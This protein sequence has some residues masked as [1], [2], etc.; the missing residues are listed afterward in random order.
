MEKFDFV[1]MLKNV[2][3]YRITNLTL[4]PPVVVMLAK[5]PETRNFDLSS[6]KFIGSGAAP[7]SREVSEEVENMWPSGTINVKQGW[8]MTEYVYLYLSIVCIGNLIIE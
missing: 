8:G 4:V 2:E 6:V 3:R 7:L 1:T 5:H